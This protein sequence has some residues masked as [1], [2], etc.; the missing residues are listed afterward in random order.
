MERRLLLLG[1]LR[2]QEMHGYQLNDFIDTHLGASVQLTKP[3]AYHLLNKM[4][5]EG[6]I[7]YQDDKE[8]NRPPRRVYKITSE[9][10]VAFQA[11]LRECLADY[12]PAEFRS[13][14]PL[15]FLEEMPAVEAMSLLHQRRQA[16]EAL[17]RPFRDHGDEH[18]VGS[19]GLLVEHRKRH[20]MA[21]LAWVDEVVA[22]LAGKEMQ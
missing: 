15:A 22:H 5:E 10:E 1:M 7:S 6:L 16:I 11:L 9:G 20:L 13:D 19:F 4:T 12:R 21:E 8:G 18:D 17:L 3:T 14:I 2:M